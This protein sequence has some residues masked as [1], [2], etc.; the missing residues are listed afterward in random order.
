MFPTLKRV[1][2]SYSF[3]VILQGII[4]VWAVI[5]TT[6]F[7]IRQMPGN[8]VDIKIDELMR[9]Q[10][11][12]LEQATSQAA[13]LF[14]FD[15]DKPLFEQ[16]LDY[17]G[18][19]LRGDMGNSVTATGT[20]VI[21]QILRYLPWTLFSVGSAL[22]I[23][24][25]IGIFAGMAIA[26]WRGS[27]LDNLLTAFSSIMY[28]IPDFL[29]ALL[30]ILIAGVQL[31]WFQVGDVLGG[32]DPEIESGFNAAYLQSLL[33][34]AALPVL[35]YILTSVGGWILTM[36][37]S[38]ISTLGE[39]FITVAHARGL[40]ERRILTTYVGRNAML[41]LVTRL[42]ISIGFVV[43][44]SV[45]VESIF[46]Y[47]GLGRLLADA[48]RF[49]DYTTMQGVFLVIAFSVVASNILADLVYG[50]LDPR[51]RLEKK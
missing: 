48:I 44:G 43:G 28:G 13:G 18:K 7:L 15:P 50:F 41:P 45:I 36:K 17:M 24:F 12:S 22:L 21:D 5:T 38:T 1:W 14:D 9:T 40:S 30:M 16:Y 25:T 33:Q 47:P 34:H 23:S 39:D 19:L 6:F 31:K 10:N 35:T 8:P 3:Q 37:S 51:V 32:S 46:L 4:T 27:V 11:L 2:Q 42:A 20:Q 29:I 26:Y 49:R